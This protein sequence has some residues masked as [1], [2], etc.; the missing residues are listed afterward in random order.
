MSLNACSSSLTYSCVISLR[1]CDT[2]IKCICKSLLLLE[3]HDMKSCVV[4]AMTLHA[5]KVLR[6]EVTS[7]GHTS[8]RISK[9]HSIKHRGFTIILVNP[10]VFIMYSQSHTHPLSL[11]SSLTRT[12]NF[13]RCT[14]H[15]EIYVVHSSANANLLIWL[16]Y[17]NLH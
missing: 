5:F 15:F 12:L 11:V 17:L 7:F 3:S 16:K 14:V 8:L 13:F 2:R 4:Y 6:S 10:F 9:A 1:Y